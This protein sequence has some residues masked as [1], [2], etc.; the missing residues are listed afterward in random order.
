MKELIQKGVKFLHP[1]S[2]WVD[3]SVHPDNIHASAVI[4]PGC[5]ITG[6][7][8]SIGPGCIIGEETPATIDNCQLGSN[9]RLKGGFFAGSAFLDESSIGSA[10][11]VRPGC[12]LEEQA[13][14]GHAAGLKQTVLFPFVITG[15][16]INF[17]DCLMSGGTSRGDHSEVGSSFVHFNY[18]P[19]GDKA[20]ASLFGN[21]PGGITLDRKRIFL[22]GHSG[23][24]GPVS[25]A[26]G[27]ILAAGSILR[28]SCCTEDTLIAEAAAQ[29]KRI[30][31]AG[32][33]RRNMRQIIKMNLE[34]IGN[35]FALREWYRR[36]RLPASAGSVFR[37]S[38]CAGALS[39]L[40]M[41]LKERI[42][43]LSEVL[44]PGEG[45]TGADSDAVRASVAMLEKEHS[46]CPQQD[47]VLMQK[48]IS[49][50]DFKA[51]ASSYTACIK[52]MRPDLKKDIRTWLES[53]V[54]SVRLICP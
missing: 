44:E 8:T 16:L 50:I 33:P 25:V 5:R 9:V 53:I 28:R 1:E 34:Y 29:A 15:S 10:A 24:V 43:R 22:G 6:S 26:F 20:T 51:A 37:E 38:C 32:R 11:H 36:I 40:D 45:F 7:R 14:C 49:S 47:L 52:A 17:C 21:V 48:V 30:A 54:D 41:I 27:C 4:H 3:E 39:C 31:F 13:S 35:I 23:A 42:S 2:T 12:I 19:Y 18:T 46:S